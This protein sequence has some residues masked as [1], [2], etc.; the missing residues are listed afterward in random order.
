MYKGRNKELKRIFL[1]RWK[2]YP[3]YINAY[4]LK[5]RRQDLGLT[6]KE[7]AEKFGVDRNTINRWENGLI[8]DENGETKDI[9][10]WVELALQ[11]LEIEHA[12][13]VKKIELEQAEGEKE[14][15]NL[16]SLHAFVSRKKETENETAEA[17]EGMPILQG[18]IEYSE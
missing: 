13:D 7:L 16:N 5:A 12:K 10:K 3:D 15:K 17:E 6:Q 8:K 9:P 18:F 1:E 4:I 14:N 2:H 11:A